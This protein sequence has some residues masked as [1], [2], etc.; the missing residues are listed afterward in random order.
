M[1]GPSRILPSLKVSS[2]SSEVSAGS[3]V[4]DSAAGPTSGAALSATG[5]SVDAEVSRYV[6]AARMLIGR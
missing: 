2:A 3:T 4:P 1:G 6:A 5:S